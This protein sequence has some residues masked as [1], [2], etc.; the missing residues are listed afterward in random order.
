V[1]RRRKY[2]FFDEAFAKRNPVLRVDFQHSHGNAADRR[3]TQQDWA[4]PA[5]MTVPF[6]AARIEQGN[7]LFR[8]AITAGNARALVVVARETREA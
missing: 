6:L 8:H 1:S 2:T 5:K 3:P 4:I 7:E